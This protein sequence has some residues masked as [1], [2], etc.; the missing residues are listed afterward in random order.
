MQPIL[1][2]ITKEQYDCLVKLTTEKEPPLKTIKKEYF[3]DDLLTAFLKE[4]AKEKNIENNTNS[5]V[6]FYKLFEKITH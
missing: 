4:Y 3:F 6:N 1:P 2:I 5:D